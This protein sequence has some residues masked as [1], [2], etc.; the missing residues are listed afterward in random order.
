MYIINNKI[1]EVEYKGMT[2]SKLVDM[3]AKQILQISLEKNTI[4]PKH[5]SPSDAQ[6][7]LLEG[8]VSFFIN[9]NEYQISKHQVFSFPK[10]EEHW[11]KANENSKFLIIR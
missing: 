11:V 4:F 6:L 10:N 2:T 8:S 5:I 3:D 7:L 1:N 9:K